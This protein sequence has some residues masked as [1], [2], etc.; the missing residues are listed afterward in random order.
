[1][2]FLFYTLLCCLYAGTLLVCRFIS[3]THNMRQCTI[4]PLQTAL[5]IVNFIEAVVFGLF[6]LIMMFDQLTA[7]L[8]N[9]PGIDALQNRQ[10][11]K[12]GRYDSL[13]AVFGEGVSVRWL[14][15]LPLPKRVEK[16]FEWELGED[17]GEY[18]EMRGRREGAGGGGGGGLGDEKAAGDVPQWPTLAA[19]MGQSGAKEGEDGVGQQRDEEKRRKED[20]GEARKDGTRF[21]DDDKDEE[22]R[23]Q[24]RA[25]RHHHHHHHHHHP[26]PADQHKTD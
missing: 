3:C 18:G 17:A 5:C 15:P 24:Q 25:A 13:Q 23:R 6:C 8:D 12:R 2:L 7:I 10:G 20:E 4:T 21:G 9:T 26:Q 14:L 19:A 1:M 11:A 22:Q 16:E